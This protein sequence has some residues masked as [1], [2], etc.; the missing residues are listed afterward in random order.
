[1]NYLQSQNATYQE[2]KN[3]LKRRKEATYDGHLHMV[4]EI[5]DAIND[6][7]V[8]YVFTKH[9]ACPGCAFYGDIVDNPS[10]ILIVLF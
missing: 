9:S 8:I 2:A 7:N 1:M 3:R 10:T 6:D 5:M 4:K